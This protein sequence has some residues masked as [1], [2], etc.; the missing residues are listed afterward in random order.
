MSTEYKER[1]TICAGYGVSS[2]STFY[3]LFDSMRSMM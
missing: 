2:N 1:F 3:D